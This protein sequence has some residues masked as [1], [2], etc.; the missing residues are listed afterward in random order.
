MQEKRILPEQA[1]RFRERVL[2]D[3]DTA[4]LLTILP[5]IIFKITENEDCCCLFLYDGS[6]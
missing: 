1:Q 3:L 2:T 4:K 5:E 6:S